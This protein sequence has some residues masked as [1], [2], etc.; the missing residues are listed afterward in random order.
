LP[1]DHGLSRLITRESGNANRPTHAL[2]RWRSCVRRISFCPNRRAQSKLGQYRTCGLDLGAGVEYAFTN[3]LIGGIEYN[4]YGFPGEALS[5]GIN[6]TTI[7]PRESV[8]TVVGKAATSSDRHMF[9]VLADPGLA[10]LARRPPTGYGPIICP[11]GTPAAAVGEHGGT[12]KRSR[13]PQTL[14]PSASDLRS[15]TFQAWRE[16]F[17]ISYW[18]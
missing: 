9:G 15:P 2:P 7:S 3:H 13:F 14:V 1:D 17:N 10:H 18:N 11:P 16:H 6:P 8:N 12:G 5:G 4:F